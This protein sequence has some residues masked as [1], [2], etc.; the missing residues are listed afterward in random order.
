MADNTTATSANPNAMMANP[1]AMTGATAASVGVAGHAKGQQQRSRKDKQQLFHANLLDGQTASVKTP[2]LPARAVQPM[3][4][5]P[6][7]VARAL[8]WINETGRSALA[9]APARQA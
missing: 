2:R 3:T 5:I 6:Q 1:N 9:R 8:T 4:T 7:I